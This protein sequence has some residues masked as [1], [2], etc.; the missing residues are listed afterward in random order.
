VR[1]SEELWIDEPETVGAGHV[2]ISSHTPV[3][4]VIG[5]LQTS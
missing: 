3:A 4:T 5:G 2:Y 1:P